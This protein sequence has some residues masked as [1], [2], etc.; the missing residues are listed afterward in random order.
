MEAGKTL[1]LENL[2]LKGGMA[3]GTGDASLGGAIFA[4][5]ATVNIT[6]CTLTGNKA[7]YNGGGIY[8]KKITVT[9]SAVTISG[10]TIGGTTA[11]DANKAAD[12]GGGI[13]IDEGCSL[14]LK[15]G[16][17]VIGNTAVSGG[18]VYTR[19]VFEMTG[20]E[21]KSNTAK[22][23]GGIYVKDAGAT[24]TMSGGTISENKA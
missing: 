13:Y 7:G 12:Y 6:N 19:G 11:A 24:L 20:G 10:C 16:A 21:I 8:A 14:T 2:T 4:S 18:G 23:G 17:K 15:D 1:R 22:Y 9:P 3:Q 5:G